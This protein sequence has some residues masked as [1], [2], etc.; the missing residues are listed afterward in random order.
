MLNNQVQQSLGSERS[1]RLRLMVA[2]GAVTQ[3]RLDQ[4]EAEFGDAMDN[5]V[6]RRTLYGS[7]RIEDFTK[8]QSE[9]MVAAA[10]RMVN[11]LKQRIAIATKKVE[12]GLLSAG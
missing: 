4:A 11:R 12:E 5:D 3:E 9:S 6:L 8:E 2:S 10:E 1:K 7:L